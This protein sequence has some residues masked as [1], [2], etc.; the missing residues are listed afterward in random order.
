MVGSARA[1][2]QRQVKEVT[3]TDDVI[4]FNG[5]DAT[6][7]DPLF[8]P[9]S[10]GDLAALIRGEPVDLERVSAAEKLLQLKSSGSFGL[11]EGESP[12]DLTQAGWGVVFHK[13]EDVG[14]K[15]Q[16]MRLYDHR[17]KQVGDSRRVKV[18]EYAGE[19]DYISWLQKYQVAPGSV[20]PWRVPFYLLLVGGPERIPFSFVQ[21]LNV[22]YS[23]GLLHFDAVDKYR[24]YVDSVIAY[25]TGDVAPRAKEAVFFRTNKDRATALS[26]LHLVGPLADGVPETDLDPAQPPVA[27]VKGFATR[28]IWDDQATA[29]GLA[30]VFAPPADQAS[31]QTRSMGAPATWPPSRPTPYRRPS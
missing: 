16:L 26:A 10:E 27:E 8:P 3:V 29:E 20:K 19:A 22:E 11:T 15:Q 13:D 7:G 4:Y 17:C 30:Q 18:L 5:V 24:Q 25:E 6:T 12:T 28:R 21:M 31:V 2:D 14:V 9:I 23:V 1:T